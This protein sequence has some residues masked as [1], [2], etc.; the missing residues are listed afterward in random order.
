SHPGVPRK[1]SPGTTTIMR[2]TV[3]S[4]VIG[5]ESSGNSKA[6]TSPSLARSGRSRILSSGGTR[7]SAEVRLTSAGRLS[8]FISWRCRHHRCRHHR[9]RCHH[10]RGGGGQQQCQMELPSLAYHDRHK[11][12]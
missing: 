9:C 1:T 6:H 8:L 4:T 2:P 12:I 5:T 11:L 7:R 3:D 10:C